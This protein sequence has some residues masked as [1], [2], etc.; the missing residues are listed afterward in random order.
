MGKYTPDEA[1]RIAD[2]IEERTRKE[3]GYT[4][5]ATPNY[6]VQIATQNQYVTNYEAH[7][8]ADD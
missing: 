1:R 6:N 2:E 5:V 3:D 7:D 8:C 4:V